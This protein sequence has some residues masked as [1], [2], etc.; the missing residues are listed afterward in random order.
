MRK[1]L[2]DKQAEG[3]VI[4]NIR[5]CISAIFAE[6]VQRELVLV[7]PARNPGKVFRN[8]APKRRIQFLNKEQVAK[9]LETVKQHKPEY[10]DLILTA[11][12]TGMRLG[13][14]RALAWDCVNFDTKQITVRRS[15]SHNH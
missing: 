7:N 4:S 1:F 10:H 11:F 13:E 5:I 6:A 14:V 8:S 2:F 15:Y 12:R 3:L 9:F